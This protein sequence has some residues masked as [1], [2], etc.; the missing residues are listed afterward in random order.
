MGVALGDNPI[1]EGADVLTT[2]CSWDLEAALVTE[3]IF[4]TIFG[5]KFTGAVTG[6]ESPKLRICTDSL[7]PGMFVLVVVL[8]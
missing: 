8:I 6:I 3:L 7:S 2:N 4:E 1:D 5:T